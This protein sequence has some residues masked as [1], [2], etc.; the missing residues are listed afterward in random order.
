MLEVTDRFQPR[1]E[2]VLIERVVAA[3]REFV[4]RPELKISLL[5][6]NDEEI[7]G[8][9]G[10]FLGDFTPTDVM[11]FE[12]D[13]RDRQRLPPLHRDRRLPGTDAHS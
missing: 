9:H 8:L 12:P 10:R 6:T 2:R 4:E 11:S 3:V 1:T 13:H 5:L 7:A